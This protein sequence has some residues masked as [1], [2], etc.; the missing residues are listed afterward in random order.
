MSPLK[1]FNRVA[2]S[3]GFSEVSKL[4][5]E[6]SPLKSSSASLL[7]TSTVPGKRDRPDSAPHGR[8]YESRQELP[9]DVRVVVKP[10][11]QETEGIITKCCYSYFI[12]LYP[13]KYT[14]VKKKGVKVDDPNS[15]SFMPALDS[16]EP[17]PMLD[18]S[19]VI[20]NSGTTQ[21]PEPLQT[22][23]VLENDYT[24]T[25]DPLYSTVEE[26]D[27]S[28]RSVAEMAAYNPALLKQLR[29]HD[30]RG[31]VQLV[32]IK[33]TGKPTTSGTTV[34]SFPENSSADMHAL[35]YAAASGDKKALAENISALPMSQD[36]VEMVLG[37]EK[38]VRREGID[39]ADSEGR[40]PLMHAVHNNQLHAVKVLAENGANVNVIAAGELYPVGPMG[41][42]E[43]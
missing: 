34:M 6:A 25:P 11:N 23:Q 18:T 13:V 42:G 15:I 26:V 20:S 32:S 39:V 2:P 5:E 28:E 24:T 33:E 36:T 17:E 19:I 30:D 31:N 21:Q 29:K 8:K 38:L 43:G 7:E 16:Y 27:T 3:A 14:L 1:K 10:C 22:S 12:I 40:S 35:H 37:S 41:E 4:I 9:I